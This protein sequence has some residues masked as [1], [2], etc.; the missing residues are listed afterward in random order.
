LRDNNPAIP[1]GDPLQTGFHFQYPLSSAAVQG[2]H[3]S[4]SGV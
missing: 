1:Y 2:Y 3:R 4:S